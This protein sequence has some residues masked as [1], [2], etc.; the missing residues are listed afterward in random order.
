MRVSGGE[1]QKAPV[2]LLRVV[3]KK[4]TRSG[5]GGRRDQGAVLLSVSSVND[6]SLLTRVSGCTTSHVLAVTGHWIKRN[7]S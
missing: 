6:A 7:V 4:E 5:N 3:E 1:G 2:L